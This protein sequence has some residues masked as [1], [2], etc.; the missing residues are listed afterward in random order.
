MNLLRQN[1][2]SYEFDASECEL[3]GGKCC[4]G[5]SGYIWI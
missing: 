3:C 1:G 2:F 5:E 4:T